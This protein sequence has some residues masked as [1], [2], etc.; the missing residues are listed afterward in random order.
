MI[1]SHKHRFVFVAVPK[2][3]SQSIRL[4]FRPFLA[5]GDEEQATLFDK[6]YSTDPH[7]AAKG[8]GHFTA[9]EL[10]EHLGPGV[11]NSYFTFG[12]VRNPWERFASWAQFRLAKDPNFY[13]FP[14]LFM[15]AA[16]VSGRAE[17]DLWAKPQTDFLCGENNELLVDY[18]GKLETTTEALENISAA[19]GLP[20]SG[21]SRLNTG[22]QH[23]YW[24]WFDSELISMVGTLY[25]PDIQ[26][27]A[28]QAK[29]LNQRP[30]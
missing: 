19:I 15:K 22:Q 2:V 25:Q 10:K 3:A 6:L 23:S 5:D 7:M 4:A 9:S 29:V 17:K 14:T 27:F 8:H 24:S 20:V 26:L 18:V 11:W 13:R 30:S 1:I 28:Y 16:I 21:I 12:F